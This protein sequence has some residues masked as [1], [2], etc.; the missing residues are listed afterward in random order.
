MGKI[1]QSLAAVAL[2]GSS[3]FADTLTVDSLVTISGE[4]VYNNGTNTSSTAVI[5][6][7]GELAI[8]SAGVLELL[9]E[10]GS[11]NSRL[12]LSGGKL[13]VDGK[14]KTN[15]IFV[16][17]GTNE[18]T[19]N[20]ADSI[21]KSNG[22]LSELMF[23]SGS[24]TVNFNASHDFFVWDTRASGLKLVFAENTSTLF[25][26]IKYNSTDATVVLQ[27]FGSTNS[28]AFN[29]TAYGTT[30]TYDT[31][32][33]GNKLTFSSETVGKTF[34][35]TFVDENGNALDLNLNNSGTIATLTA[36]VPEP[37][38]WA[39]IFGAIALVAAIYRRRK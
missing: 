20:S 36:A 16:Q 23:I 10:E 32:L 34:T 1:L 28:I 19:I 14:L 24:L 9:N 8:E 2:C 15:A 6:S 4:E 13:V 18:I 26:S 12:Q 38:E 22:T 30:K 25:D 11:S 7:G 31:S 33:D 3:L 27:D 35:L 5:K 21:R 17:V 39:A 37:A 29:T